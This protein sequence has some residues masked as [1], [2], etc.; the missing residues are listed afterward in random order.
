MRRKKFIK[1]LTIRKMPDEVADAVQG[2]AEENQI[3]FSKA[4]VTLLQEHLS[5]HQSKQKKKR[6]LSWFTG[7]WSEEEAQNF[8]KALK[9]QRRIDPEMW[10]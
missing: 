6:D 7:K 4:L 9:E 2:R 8:D 3:S 1:A 10:K 5:E